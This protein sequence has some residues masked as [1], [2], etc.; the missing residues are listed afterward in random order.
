VFGLVNGFTEHWQIVT[1]SNYSAISNSHTLQFTTARTK[2]SQPAVSSLVDV[3]LLLG[4]H[5]RRLA[6]ISH[7]PPILLTAVS[8]P[9]CKSKSKSKLL[10]D[11]RFTANQF[12]LASNPLRPT[13]RIFIQLNSCGNS[14][15]VTS[16]LTR[17]WGCLS[18]ICLAHFIPIACYWTFLP[19]ALHKS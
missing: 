11:W 18:W 17:R 3:L 12:V 16:S 8:R 10:Y 1:T 19:F 13:T 9:S 4:S 5:P 2:Y 14:P 7:Q 15:Y 6:A